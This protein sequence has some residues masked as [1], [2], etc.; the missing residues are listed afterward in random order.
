MGMSTPLALVGA[1]PDMLRAALRA[2]GYDVRPATPEDEVVLVGDRPDP[3]DLPKNG[4]TIVV[5]ATPEA[6]GQAYRAGAFFAVP[7]D[8]TALVEV[9]ERA[10]RVAA[11]RRA[12]DGWRGS[13]LAS[14]E[15]EAILSAM[16]AAAGSTA[17]AAAMLDISVRK[18]QYKLHEY[19]F[20]LTRRG[21]AKQTEPKKAANG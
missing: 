4:V 7:P 20:P 17:R 8:A 2:R 3:N 1:L 10:L 21:G 16:K 15:R 13:T 12:A 18:V 19:G 9:V 6:A 14:L 11:D 5:S